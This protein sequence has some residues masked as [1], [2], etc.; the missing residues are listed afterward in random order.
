MPLLP[1]Q[2]RASVELPGLSIITAHVEA[3]RRGHVTKL[4]VLDVSHHFSSVL[5]GAAPSRRLLL[6]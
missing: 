2:H 3:E 4:H 1:Q 5:S 6:P